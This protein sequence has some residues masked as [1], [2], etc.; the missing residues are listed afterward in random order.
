MFVAGT[1]LE[2]VLILLVL[3]AVRLLAMRYGV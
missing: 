3:A 2:V 1:M